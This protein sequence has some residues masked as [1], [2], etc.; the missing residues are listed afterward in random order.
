MADEENEGYTLSQ[1]TAPRVLKAT[2][3]VEREPYFSTQQPSPQPLATPVAA[4]VIASD[5]S[6]YSE[7]E[8]LLPLGYRGHVIAYRLLQ[9]F[10]LTKLPVVSDLDTLLK[11]AASSGG[12]RGVQ[13][14]VAH[15]WVDEHADDDLGR[16]VLLNICRYARGAFFR[17]QVVTASYLPGFRCSDAWRGTHFAYAAPTWGEW[18][19]AEQAADPKF[20]AQP[21]W[22]VIDPGVD[23][24]VATLTSELDPQAD[25]EYATAIIKPHDDVLE[26]GKNAVPVAPDKADSDDGP[27]LYV[28]SDADNEMVALA[29]ETDQTVFWDQ[30]RYRW[31]VPRNPSNQSLMKQG[32][33]Q[34]RRLTTDGRV[35][36]SAQMNG[37]TNLTAEGITTDGE[38]FVYANHSVTTFLVAVE[39]FRESDGM[40]V[41]SFTSLNDNNPGSA[42]F[43]YDIEANSSYFYR[44]NTGTVNKYDAST[45]VQVWQFSSTSVGAGVLVDGDY[46]YTGG[47]SANFYRLTDPGSSA[48]AAVDWTA[49]FTGIVT[50]IAKDKTSGNLYVTTDGAGA[51]VE[52]RSFD[53]NGTAGWTFEHSAALYAVAVSPVNGDVLIGGARGAGGAG[54][55]HVRCLS[56]SGSERWRV[57]LNP[58]SAQVNAV[59]YDSEGNCYIGLGG[60]FAS[61]PNALYST[62]GTS[63]K[64]IHSNL[65][66]YTGDG[67]L[68]WLF[69]HGL[70]N[71]GASGFSDGVRAIHIDADDRIFIAGGCTADKVHD[72]VAP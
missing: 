69:T 30:L 26:S 59:A 21:G 44:S 36:W 62:G 37:N 15:R 66:K 58:F 71:V 31:Q 50:A 23:E 9:D 51:T 39:K 12:T 3:R 54:N 4:F 45:G 34:I 33:A 22:C 53:G 25:P 2:L 5:P 35:V 55:A 70:H 47:G 49:T 57:D 18:P 72:A 28:Y 14:W 32:P 60:A 52:V 11:K 43:N 6:E 38:G 8:D 29:E 7:P 40:F 24:V 41:T 42:N 20:F 63:G 19:T 17:G 16:P 64:R 27:T 46:I 56:S 61:I 65:R 67:T 48:P 1:D 13:D 68:V 10:D